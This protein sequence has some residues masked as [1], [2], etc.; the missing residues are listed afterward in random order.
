MYFRDTSVQQA[1]V[2]DN[3]TDF[4]LNN[5]RLIRFKKIVYFL[6]FIRK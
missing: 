2:K 3:K 1:L 4:K 5:L 6:E